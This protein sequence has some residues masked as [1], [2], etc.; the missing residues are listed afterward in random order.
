MKIS[1]VFVTNRKGAVKFLNKQ[2][3]KQTFK[4]FEVIIAN[5]NEDDG[6]FKPRQKKDGDC[7]NINKAYNDCL[8]KAKGELLVFLQDFIEINANGLQRFWDLYTI[9]P[10]GL[11]TGCGHKYNEDG[12]INEID[13]RVFG[14]KKCERIHWSCWELNWASCPRDIMPRFNEDMDKRYGGE[15][16]YIANI[17]DKQGYLTYLDRLNECRGWSQERCGGRPD[18]WEILHYNKYGQ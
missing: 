6:G 12:S 11:I 14:D 8:D 7:W 5:D 16:Q 1:V 17:A 10:Q 3:A 4:D 9:Y 18:D 2:L 15:N 13:D